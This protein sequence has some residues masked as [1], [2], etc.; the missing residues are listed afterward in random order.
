MDE[1]S[2][3][4]LID[5]NRN[6]I[7]PVMGGSA[8]RA[9]DLSVSNPD[10]VSTVAGD[11][12]LLTSYIESQ[13]K[14]H[15]NAFLIGGY[16]EQRSVYSRFGLFDDQ[17]E[18]RNFHLGIDIWADAGTPVFAPLDGIVHSFD[19]LPAAGDYGVIIILQHQLESLNFYTLYGHLSKKDIE[20]LQ[21]DDTIA[22]GQ[23]FA[24]LGQ[25]DENGNWP[26]HLHL[27]I[28]LDIGT[29][30]ADYPGVCKK[31]EASAY[32]ANSPD[33]TF[34]LNLE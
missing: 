12:N 4:R 20:Y 14:K 27:Q 32:I 17:D 28:I 24:H 6:C 9:V 11:L 31:S 15:G 25:P 7:H 13:R 22:A 33:P 26:P 3:K 8:F 18:P 1:A 23:Q 5:N 2:I 10:L 19:F 34:L 21:K 16:G 30:E 29:W